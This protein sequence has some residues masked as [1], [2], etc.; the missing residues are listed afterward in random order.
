MVAGGAVAIFA[1]AALAIDGALLMSTRTQLHNAADAAALAGATALITGDE[2]EATRRAI[3]TAG[4]NVA[5]QQTN[6]PV[7]ITE[8]DV[9][10]PEHDV[11]RVETH[12]T[13]AR[14]DALRTFFMRVIDPGSDNLADMTAVAKARAYDIC[15]SR[16]LKPWAIPDAWEDLNGNGT[17]NPG[18]YYHP[19]E[20]G[21][22]A[23][24]D[25]GTSVV[26]KVGRASD[27]MA[28]GI[29]YVVDFPP[30][31]S[32]EGK[33]LTGSAWYRR[34][35]ADCSPYMIE[36]GDRLQLEPGRMV[37][38]TSQAVEELVDLDPGAYW[39]AST[40]TV[41]G[42]AFALSPRVGLIPFFD[43]TLPPV[44]GRN[45]VTVV[46]LGA[47]F[48]EGVDSA[49]QVRGR[50]IQITTQGFPCPGGSGSAL[51]KGIALIE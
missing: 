48:I 16:C 1:F 22:I 9:T 35:V 42:S 26:L 13:R 38:P 27:T 18:E 30:L 2:D 34:W 19:D 17:W 21:Y 41:Q 51:V 43:P 23:P 45:Y 6:S 5:Y 44:S 3:Q 7:L 15:S 4:R 33:P 8:E 49:S 31:G 28:S 10:F 39:D 36:I 20:T 50:F 14:G 40:K 32:G 37:G 29:F 12:R 46:K 11:I 24:R 25:V 47:F